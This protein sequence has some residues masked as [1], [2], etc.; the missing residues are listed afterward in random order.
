MPTDLPQ[1][2]LTLFA[3]A[4]DFGLYRAAATKTLQFTAPTTFGCSATSIRSC[5]EATENGGYKL[6]LPP[7]DYR[8]AA[9]SERSHMV[10]SDARVSS[11]PVSVP[12]L[13]LDESR[14]M[15]KL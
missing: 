15:G 8:I 5:T 3:G 4:V 12:L 9:W 6:E 7:G 10:S 14:S 1:R 2:V 13:T 11:A